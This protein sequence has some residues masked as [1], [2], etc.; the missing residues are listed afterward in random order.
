MPKFNDRDDVLDDAWAALDDGDPEQSLRLIKRLSGDDP[1]RSVVD[2]WGQ[3][4]SVPNL[5]LID[6]SIFVTSAGTN[7]TTTI[8]ALALRTADHILRERGNLGDAARRPS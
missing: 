5:F 1:A 2:R 8:Q 4:H 3:A 6:G 7:P